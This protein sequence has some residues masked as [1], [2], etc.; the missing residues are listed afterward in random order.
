MALKFIIKLKFNLVCLQIIQRLHWPN[1]KKEKRTINTDL[2]CIPCRRAEIP[3][4]KVLKPDRGILGEI[5]EFG[6]T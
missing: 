6:S 5:V 3:F 1:K 4:C 2:E